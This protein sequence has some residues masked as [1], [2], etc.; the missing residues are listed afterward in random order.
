[1]KT[2]TITLF[3]LAALASTSAFAADPTNKVD[4][5]DGTF[6]YTYKGGS[7]RQSIDN[8][9]N[10]GYLILDSSAGNQYASGDLTTKSITVVN[11]TDKGYVK[12]AN[13]VSWNGSK[14]PTID[15]NA[16]SGDK[17]TAISA[18]GWE[19]NLISLTI[20]N[21]VA[22]STVTALV[23]FGKLI[24]TASAADQYSNIKFDSVKANVSALSG[25]QIGNNVKGND[26]NEIS[27][28]NKVCLTVTNS[29][30]VDW[31]GALTMG[32]HSSLDV[33]GNLTLNNSFIMDNGATFNV[34]GTLIAKDYVRFSNEIITNVNFTQDTHIDVGTNIQN[35][36]TLNSGATWTAAGKVQIDKAGELVLNEGSKYILTTTTEE[37]DGKVATHYGSVILNGGTLTLNAENVL[38]ASNAS[39]AALVTLN[40]AQDSNV[41]VNASTKV[42][43]IYVNESILNIFLADNAEFYTGSVDGNKGEIRFYNFKEGMVSVA[44][45]DANVSKVAQLVKL[46]DADDKFLGNAVLGT[47]GFLTLVPEPAEWA[48]IFGAIALGLAIYRRRK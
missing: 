13:T 21:S 17:V 2:K 1:M 40:K 48:A 14:G 25:A 43:S 31:N 32:N 46:Y 11:G 3:T 34:T 5:G 10:D 44:Y 42:S 45:N 47:D 29:A 41:N 7:S 24:V 6:T 27:L 8:F 16:A 30:D 37:T 20:K 23:D 33:A 26:G 9:G 18:S 36:I 15:I 39:K 28:N 38:E 22:N 4:N 19:Q 35:K 12:I